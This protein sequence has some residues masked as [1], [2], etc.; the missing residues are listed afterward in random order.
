MRISTPQMHQSA[1][2]GMLEQQSRLNRTQLEI[3]SGK[4]IQSPADDPSGATAVLALQRTLA[5]TE[6]YQKNAES[7]RIRLSQEEDL[8][9][10]INHVLDRVRE[11]SLQANNAALSAN[12]RDMLA[13]EVEQRLDEIRGYANARDAN[14]EYLFAGYQSSAQPF[15]VGGSGSVQYVGDNGRRFV[16]IGTDRQVAIGDSGADVFMAIRNGNGW[17]TTAPDPG[18]AGS[19]IVTAGQ[20]TDGRLYQGQRYE[21][22]FTAADGYQVLDDRGS[23][24]TTGAYSSE[25]GGDIAFAGVSLRISGEPAT[26]DR[27]TIAPSTNQDIFTTL[28]ETISAMRTGEPGP[29]GSAE[30]ANAL[31]RAIVDIDQAMEKVRQ[32]RADVGARLN[33]VDSQTDLNDAYRLQL[34][35]SLSDLQ[36]LDYADAVTRLNRH[37][38][39]LQAAQQ[40]YVRIQSLSLFNFL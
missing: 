40:S 10:K 34:Q 33:I 14:G 12:D 21:I 26:G 3:A 25:T 27:F 20:V 4:R 9:A 19:G 13:V 32:V 30:R 29:K 22:V 31:G 7:V 24:V 8:L 6:Q 15:V 37:M 28:Q 16:Q 11:L 38:V 23:V 36:D 35:S 17:F 5:S 1:L 39:G 18:N 2:N